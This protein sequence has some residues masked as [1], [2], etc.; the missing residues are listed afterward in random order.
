MTKPKEPDYSVMGRGALVRHCKALRAVLLA[1][2]PVEWAKDGNVDASV[3]WEKD[4]L[5]VLSTTPVE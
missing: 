4:A 2:S 3:A 1:A 5:Q